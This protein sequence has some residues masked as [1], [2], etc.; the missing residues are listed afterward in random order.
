MK[1]ACKLRE[2]LLQIQ[3]LSDARVDVLDLRGYDDGALPG[4]CVENPLAQTQ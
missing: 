4:G 1:N 2:T 3:T